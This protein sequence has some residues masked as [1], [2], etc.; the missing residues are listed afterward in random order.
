M[1]IFIG[2]PSAVESDRIP[3]NPLERDDNSDLSSEMTDPSYGEQYSMDEGSDGF[4][5][6]EDFNKTSTD[7]PVTNSTDLSSEMTDPS[8]G[9][10]YSMDEGSDL[11]SEMT[12][13]SYGEQY[14]MDEGSDGFNGIE[15]FSN[16]STD[17]PV[18]NSTDGFNGYEDFNNPSTDLPV[19]NSTDGFLGIEE[20]NNTS[21]DLPVTNSTDGFPGIEEENNTSTDL[22]D[23]TNLTDMTPVT[24]EKNSTYYGT[25][26]NPGS[27]DDKDEYPNVYY[28]GS[29]E[30]NEYE[31]E[32]TC[33]PAFIKINIRPKKNFTGIVYPQGVPR[34][35]KESRLCY[36]KYINANGNFTFLVPLY[37]C[38]TKPNT[39]PNAENS[40]DFSNVVVIQP[41]LYLQTIFSDHVRVRCRF[42]TK[43]QTLDS[44]ISV[45]SPRTPI[46]L[47]DVLEHAPPPELFMRVYHGNLET[48]SV[49]QE[50]TVGEPITLV[51]GMESYAMYTLKIKNCMMLSGDGK[52][53]RLIDE[54]GCPIDPSIMD[55]FSY[56]PELHFS[57]VELIALK[58][59]D[60][61]DIVFKCHASF[62]LKNQGQCGIVPPICPLSAKEGGIVDVPEHLL[63]SIYHENN[64]KRE[65]SYRETVVTSG[66]LVPKSMKSHK[67]TFKKK[68]ASS[69]QEME[70]RSMTNLPL[71]YFPRIA[72]VNPSLFRGLRSTRNNQKV[73]LGDLDYDLNVRLQVN[74]RQDGQDAKFELPADRVEMDP[75]AVFDDWDDVANADFAARHH[76]QHGRLFSEGRR[77]IANATSR[78]HGLI[79]KQKIANDPKDHQM[80]RPIDQ[81]HENGAAKE[82]TWAFDHF[83]TILI[84][85]VVPL[86]LGTAFVF[87]K[88]YKMMRAEEHREADFPMREMSIRIPRIRR[89]SVNRIRSTAINLYGVDNEAGPI[90]AR[91]VPRQRYPY[92]LDADTD[93]F[94]L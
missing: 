7:L 91:D 81:P 3:G 45:Q 49:V 76:H 48:R 75:D 52:R 62:C 1:L 6:I 41:H 21:T 36:G 18:T 64:K 26:G 92:G 51:I 93:I 77:H 46:N 85:I 47:T 57:F 35:S 67:V 53:F 43:T 12:D 65:D 4:N 37:G 70:G 15:D 38:N 9:E 71:P 60:T 5:G 72:S 30:P 11:S 31:V 23:V 10:Q 14:S 88:L 84:L 42:V 27:D 33:E 59:H 79:T 24:E 22:P 86:F 50:V 56:T 20:E 44:G 28:P 90:E 80:D 13:P 8:Y 68:M 58:F 29:N 32:V 40:I 19:T 89:L 82:N 87:Y 61:R 54:N 73:M 94:E 63:R 74:P 39:Q 17:L 16:A 55:A 34:D 66:R 2:I 83:N 69:K 25:P 78:G